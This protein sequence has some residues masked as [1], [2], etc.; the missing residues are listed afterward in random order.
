MKHFE[1]HGLHEVLRLAEK[2]YFMTSLD[3]KDAN[4]LVPAE[5]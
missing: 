4:Y 2:N 5:K 3:I 1:L